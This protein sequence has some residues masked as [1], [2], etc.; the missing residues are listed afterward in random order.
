MVELERPLVIGHRGAPGY[1][2]EHSRDSYR[3]AVRL[4]ADAV[5]TDVV[6]SKDG[7]LV[8]RHENELGRTTDVA[9][10]PEFADRRTTRR[11]GTKERTGWFVEDFTLDELRSLGA[12]TEHHRIITLDE[13]TDLL[14][15][16]SARRG[17]AVG[18]HVEVKEP[19]YFGRLGVDL[20]GT[21]LATLGEAGRDRPGSRT[22]LQSFDPDFV[23]AA[24]ERTSLP[25]V[26][27]ANHTVAPLDCAEIATYADA[28]GPKKSM[29]ATKGN[30]PSSLVRE[31]HAAGLAVFVYTLRK[32]AKQARMFYE[33]GV[34]GVFTDYPDR[35]V[36]ALPADHIARPA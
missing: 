36:A 17:R 31:A 1:L 10:R 32:G 14:A 6:V 7:A 19:A 35:C 16:E 24:R 13:L 28:V 2:P 33:A 34:D 11:V 23:R 20:L 21:V 5:E 12:P 29:V 18:L 9:S 8:L 22:W 30:P 3:L 27:L 4:G 15:E 25:L 26:Q